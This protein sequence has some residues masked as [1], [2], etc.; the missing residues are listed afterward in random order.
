MSSLL[1]G[2]LEAD[3]YTITVVATLAIGL[4]ALWY[5]S[6][7][8]G[9]DAGFAIDAAL[10]AALLGII[11][12]RIEVIV[13]N[14]GYFRERP[15]ATLADMR[16]GGIGQRSFVAVAVLAFVCIVAA[17][18]PCWRHYAAALAP[19][20]A[21]ASAVAWAGLAFVGLGAGVPIDVPFL[22]SL[23]DQYGI[24]AARLPLQFIMAGGHIALAAATLLLLNRVLQ[25]GVGLCIWGAATS[26]L[27]AVLDSFRCE[28]VYL[29]AGVPRALVADAA[30]A[31]A[32]L[33]AA[34]AIAVRGRS[35]ATASV[36]HGAPP[37]EAP[38][39]PTVGSG[40][41]PSDAAQVT[42]ERGTP[43]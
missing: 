30:L 19:A 21:T 4:A 24:V 22:V 10:A 35:Q 5:V 1:A 16:F 38:T 17:R 11:A 15:A 2:A 43:S 34:M 33:V 14:L 28:P 13:A 32:W 12:G 27:S 8:Y 37:A 23:P 31:V 39:P 26:A 42:A 25:P 3:A 29:T 36:P 41:Q 9:L 7:A 18:R 40:E 6:R 20:V